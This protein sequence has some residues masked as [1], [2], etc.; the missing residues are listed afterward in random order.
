MLISSF[1]INLQSLGFPQ[2]IIARRKAQMEA[3]KDAR[4]NGVAAFFSQSQPDKLDIRGKLS[5]IGQ[6][7]TT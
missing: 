1:P 3:F 2:E 5:P 7:F 4:K 6:K